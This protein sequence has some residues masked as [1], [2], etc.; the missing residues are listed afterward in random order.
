VGPTNQKPKPL[1]HVPGIANNAN[2][3]WYDSGADS[4]AGAPFLA[5]DHGEFLIFRY[6]LNKLFREECRDCRCVKC[7]CN[8]G[9]DCHGCNDKADEQNLE[10]MYRAMDKAQVETSGTACGKPFSE[11]CEKAAVGPNVNF[12][13]C[14]YF[15][16]KDGA[17]DQVEEHDTEV[18]Y[19]TVCNDFRD[20]T[21]KGLKLTKI[22]LVPTRPI[23]EIQIVPD[24]LICID[25]LEACSCQ[26]REFAIITRGN[27][28]AGNYALE[29]EYC[30]DEIVIHSSKE[31][32][33]AVKFPLEITED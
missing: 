23:D 32:K 5:F 26:T 11:I 2:F 33:G 3:I 7:K 14:F 20:I 31:K 12:A 10:L 19:L 29:V 27:N 18:F 17:S 24:R 1:H 9:C 13:P 28:I 16:Y 25:C 4:R 30:Y 15:H 21:Y 6:P 8:C 22:R